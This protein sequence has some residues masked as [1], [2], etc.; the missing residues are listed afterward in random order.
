[1]GRL[2]YKTKGSEK[3]EG[4]PR[5]FFACHPGDLPEY[6]QILCDDIFATHD[7]AVYY[8]EDMSQKPEEELLERFNL[9][10]VPVTNRLLTEP[11]R[12][13]DEDVPEALRRR[14]PVLPV[15]VEAVP[16]ELYADAAKFGALQYLNRVSSD[17]TEISYGEKLK[18]YL[19]SVLLSR[20][21]A[22]RIR[23]AFSARIFLSYRKKDRRYANEL[24]RMIHRHPQCEDVAIWFDEFLTPG[25]NF[26]A[27][28][29]KVL[30]ESKLFALLVTPNLL[31]EPNFVMDREYPAARKAGIRI[32]PVQMQKTDKGALLAKYEALPDCV[33][34]G[35]G[36]DDAVGEAVA[37]LMLRTPDNSPT[38]KFL[39]GLAY[40]DGIDMEVDRQRAVSLITGAARA[41][42]PEAMEKLI[43]MYT[44]GAGVPCD[45]KLA[46][47]WSSALGAY[48]YTQSY[49]MKAPEAIAVLFEKYGDAYLHDTIRHFLL[50][51]DEKLDAAETA[52]LW[53]RLTELGISEYT[54]L[55]T[56]AQQLKNHKGLALRY[57]LGDILEKSVNGRY[58]A[59]GP[60]F[61]YVPEF[62][63]YEELLCI[64]PLLTGHKAYAKMLALTR[65][66]CWIFG[67]YHRASQITQR[68]DGEKLLAAAKELSGVRLSL[69]SF[70]FTG[71]GDLQVGANVYPRCFNTREVKAFLDTGSGVLDVMKEDFADE[72]G[73][74]E[75]TMYSLLNGEWI[76]IV[77][78]P[79]RREELEK[80]LAQ[81]S[82]AKLRGLFLCQTEEES[83]HYIACNRS[84]IEVCYV[85][86]NAEALGYS[87]RVNWRNNMPL[88]QDAVRLEGKIFYFRGDAT[89]PQ[90]LRCIPQSCFEDCDTITSVW[91]PDGVTEIGWDAFCSCRSLKK[92]RLPGSLKRVQERVA[93][94]CPALTEVIIEDG[95]EAVWKS[96]FYLCTAL[97]TVTL[98]NSV[99]YIEDNAFFECH[100]LKRI[101]LSPNTE[102]IGYSAFAN[103]YELETLTLP[104]S[105]E[106]LGKG[107]FRGCTGMKALY[108][109]P[110]G[111][112]HE[113]LGLP[114]TA[115]LYYREELHKTLVV[116]GAER[117][118][119]G[120]YRDRRDFN[121]L[122]VENGVVTVEEDA[123]CGCIAMEEA[124]LPGSVQQLGK[125]CFRGCS[126]L[127]KIKLPTGL[128]ALPEGVF[129]DCSGLLEVQLPEKLEMIGENTFM[130]CEALRAVRFSQNLREIGR[131][132][133]AWCRSLAVLELPD[134]LQVIEEDAFQ[135]CDGLR[136]LRNCPLGY[137]AEYLGVGQNVKISYRKE[138]KLCTVVSAKT[139]IGE[140]QYAHRRDIGAVRFSNAPVRV[141]KQAFLACASLKELLLPEGVTDIGAEAFRGCV[142]LTEVR[143][144]DTVRRIDRGAFCNCIN[145]KKIHLPSGLQE[146][147]D[148][149]FRDCVS[150]Q[151][152]TVP[153]NVKYIS[154]KAFSGCKNLTE[155][156]LSDGLESISGEA[157]A[158]CTSL[159]CVILPD[160]VTE[161]SYGAFKNC[162]SLV[163][164]QLPGVWK[165]G[166]EDGWGGSVVWRSVFEGCTALE[167]I[168]FTEGQETI[169]RSTC[170]N[171][172]GLKQVDIPA[173]VTCIESGAFG[174]CSALETLLIPES[175]KVLENNA[176]AD[177]TGL[178]VL[179]VPRQFADQLDVVFSGVDLSFV[180]IHYL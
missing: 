91:I 53:G 94:D 176:F 137:T 155:V 152:I 158:N 39:V 29:T 2:H 127:R 120:E 4:K 133:F 74:Y 163:S 112:S 62:K 75:H 179:T 7:C 11:N 108:G 135:F 157:F 25:E 95:V 119:K 51:A 132:A 80:K 86:E 45:P 160:T 12:A 54:L 100:H 89:L 162:T 106:C 47:R 33:E 148:E 92:I 21:L 117:I 114:W 76:G 178:K 60:L 141:G 42:L 87:R 18:K 97:Q 126:A 67:Q 107:A 147:E 14:I 174:G 49:E 71:K 170:R 104:K 111:Y 125:R 93:C 5:V 144:P 96:L 50:L 154:D 129:M 24:M 167:R 82:G 16:D 77:A 68:V 85:P 27:N 165:T 81:A 140:K 102:S 46:S 171:C 6:L 9:L 28:I 109:C 36:F 38:H 13:M 145:L 66:V 55:I 1:M 61:W 17:T 70:F 30:E 173:T 169:S 26:S 130:S 99:K 34:P 156:T 177:C 151:S 52:K 113:Y 31:E 40:L 122:Y 10:V 175:V 58:P 149:A 32:L 180:E 43:H 131:K 153:G 116:P 164:V 64:L 139:E 69:C 84:H 15:L 41:G 35:N 118:E 143:I 124:V 136:E 161:L 59:Y 44:D 63:L 56:V 166:D 128:N 101:E 37:R 98:P 121:K 22:D 65:D 20:E 83:M 168:A 138:E 48:Y 88:I 73:L 19:D 146:L 79:Y 142:S 123:F 3:P 57:I 110:P 115:E 90:G 150:L 134:S 172:S 105:V 8:T 103:C 23:G 159:R 72:L 78:A